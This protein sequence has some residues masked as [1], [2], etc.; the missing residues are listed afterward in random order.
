[1]NKKNT[2]E[3]IKKIHSRMKKDLDCLWDEINPK[4]NRY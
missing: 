3:K 2:I 1:M 4:F